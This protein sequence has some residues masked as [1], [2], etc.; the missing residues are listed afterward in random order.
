MEYDFTEN[1]KL[2]ALH[3]VSACLDDN[4]MDRPLDL[5][6]EF[7]GSLSIGVNILIDAGWSQHSA[8]G[9]YGS[10]E[11]KKAIRIG[12]FKD[13]WDGCSDVTWLDGMPLS[14]AS[15]AEKH[16]YEFEKNG[17]PTKAEVA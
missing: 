3:L 16:W 4:L 17:K 9:T 10:L 11:A 12:L 14:V 6:E 13:E 1:E 2:A 8:A 7:N 15:W 5:V